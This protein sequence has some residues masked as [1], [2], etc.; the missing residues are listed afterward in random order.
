MSDS[1]AGAG[2]PAPAPDYGAAIKSVAGL[3]VAAFA[4][5]LNLIG[6]KSDELNDI[7]RNDGWRTIVVFATL[8][9]AV[10]V[11]VGSIFVG[12]TDTVTAHNVV[13]ILLVVA[14]VGTIVVGVVGSTTQTLAGG[15]VVVVSTVVGVL[16]IVLAL[17]A[18][19]LTDRRSGLL[20]TLATGLAARLKPTNSQALMLFC[21][22]VLT[23][24]ASYAAVRLQ[25][26]EQLRSTGAAVAATV[27][28]AP[29]GDTLAVTVTASKLSDTAVIALNVCASPRTVTQAVHRAA[30]GY[31]PKPCRTGCP[32]GPCTAL[33]ASDLAPDA[34]GKVNETLSI[35][36]SAA[37]YAQLV[38]SGAVTPSASKSQTTSL[39]IQIPPPPSSTGSSN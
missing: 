26:R 13:A 8:A 25:A 23:A 37:T 10:L 32:V 33:L 14:G 28:A 2:A 29:T 5:V 31:P 12:R 21:A 15:V 24:V 4:G 18:W 19:G 38:I 20:E 17:G 6:L 1:G 36:F 11:A 22:I 27:T 7:L 9:A 39:T 3:L 35:P 30:L 34:D 16:L